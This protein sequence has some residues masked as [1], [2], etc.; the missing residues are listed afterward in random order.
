MYI[1]NADD[2]EAFCQRARSYKVIAVD[3]EFLRERT[4]HPKLCLIQVAT[5]DEAAAIDPLLLEDLAPLVR[6]FED[7]SITKVFHACDQD[8]EVIYDG[9]GCTPHPVFDTQL[10]AAFLGHRMQMGLGAL[11]QAYEGVHLDKADGLTDW[12]RRPLDE[13]QLRYAE[14]DVLYL[15]RIYQAMMDDLS[16]RDRISWLEPELRAICDPRRFVRDPYDAYIH[17]KR[18]SS[19]TRRQLAI[20]R[21]VCA[22]RERSAERRNLPRKWVMSDEVVVEVC[23]RAPRT[24]EKLLRIRGM[25]NLSDRD[26]ENVVRAVNQGVN[27]DPKMYPR[28]RHRA[29]PSAELDSVIDLMYAMLRLSADECQVALPL[30][31]TREDLHAL[32]TGSKDSPLLK[33]WR[34]E[35]AGSRLMALLSGETGLT[36]KDGRVEVL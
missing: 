16:E 21:E 32:A 22:W 36:V 27:C 6:L 15:P 13:G 19:L 4:Y 23:R 26:V 29:R 17:L 10:A 25:D 7:D 8:L 35:V 12:S 1:C 18:S 24:R 14:E 3:T 28:V 31:A 33:D 2:L 30:I 9:M 5:A 20:A 34:W 11:V